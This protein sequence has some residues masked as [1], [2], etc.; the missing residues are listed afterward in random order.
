M[1]ARI[2]TTSPMSFAGNNIMRSENISD[3]GLP[4]KTLMNFAGE[5][6]SHTDSP[7]L[8]AGC[9]YGRNAVALA[10][11]G[12]SV[13]CV[14]Q[15]LERLN[16]LVRLGPN[17]LARLKQPEC[18]AGHLYPVLADLGPSQWPFCENCFAG[19]ICVLKSGEFFS[20]FLRP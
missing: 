19:I 3:L 20:L 14:D 13:V 4:S 7:F 8:D 2:E 1:D 11:R 9:G 5:M 16:A 12:L 10:S 18:E 6:A 15:K 17:H